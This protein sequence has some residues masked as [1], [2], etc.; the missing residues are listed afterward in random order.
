MCPLFSTGDILAGIRM[1]TGN[2]VELC[3][4]ELGVVED[5]SN[6][7]NV[8]PFGVFYDFRQFGSLLLRLSA[9]HIR[10]KDS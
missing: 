5:F 8:G 2:D 6:E 1:Q 9:H 7:D 10:Y 4:V 3:F